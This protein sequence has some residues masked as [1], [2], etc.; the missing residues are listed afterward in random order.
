MNHMNK[1]NLKNCTVCMGSY[2]SYKTGSKE[3]VT[4]YMCVSPVG[5]WKRKWFFW[6]KFVPNKPEGVCQFHNP[7]S[8]YYTGVSVL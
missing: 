1:K 7:K 6:K 4:S 2:E 3:D 8:V 5:E